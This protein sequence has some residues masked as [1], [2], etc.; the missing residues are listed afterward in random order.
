MGEV[1]VVVVGKRKKE[2]YRR[3]RFRVDGWGVACAL[4]A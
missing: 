2:E 4:L 1:V 3:G